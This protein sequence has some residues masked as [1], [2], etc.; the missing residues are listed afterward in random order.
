MIMCDLM[1][2][3]EEK[4]FTGYKVVAKH[5]QNGKY[6]SI[7]MG[8]C[9]NDSEI[10]P[11][12]EEQNRIGH[13]F[14]GDILK[15]ITFKNEMVGRTAVFKSLDQAKELLEE[16]MEDSDHYDLNYNFIIVEATVLEDLLGF[17]Y[18]NPVVAGRKIK[19][20]SEV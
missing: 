20:I 15:H 17:Y 7:A 14:V 10:I 8:F 12:V 5:K 19:F 18:I 9:Y 6:Y 11:V 13:Y 4:E 2:E 1:K 3:L 16:I